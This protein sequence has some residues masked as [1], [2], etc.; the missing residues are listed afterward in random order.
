MR[1]CY[2]INNAIQWIINVKDTTYKKSFPFF[3]HSLQL[4][5]P[6]KLAVISCDKN[7]LN[8]VC[9]LTLSVYESAKR[10]KTLK[11]AQKKKVCNNNF[12]N[13]CRPLNTWASSNFLPSVKYIS[14]YCLWFNII[15]LIQQSPQFIS[16]PWS[17]TSRK[18][19][20]NFKHDKQAILWSTPNTLFYEAR[21]ARKF[22]EARQ[23]R[24]F[25]KYVRHANV[26]K[27][28][29]HTISWSKPST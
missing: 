3:H 1:S 12:S 5:L 23:A 28:A 8:N 25:M 24:H 26:L 11:N 7:L 29:K 4:F 15:Y 19:F 6:V 21:Q 9:F 27:H 14:S 10:N 17:N 13:F 2:S 20:I 16:A 18:H 22:F